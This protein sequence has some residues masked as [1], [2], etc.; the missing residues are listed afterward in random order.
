MILSI[1]YKS[2]QVGNIHLSPFQPDKYGKP[3][4]KLAYKDSSIEFHDVCVLTPPM[5]V[6]DYNPETSRLRLDLTDQTVFQNK[7]HV[8]QEFLMSTFYIHQN[9]FLS[10][11]ANIHDFHSIF[12]LLLRDNILS[13]YIFP[14]FTMK[15]DDNTYYKVSDL[16][17]GDVIRCVIRFSG[18]S[19]IQTRNGLSLRIQHTIPSM[20]KISEK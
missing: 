2:L 12:N 4:A 7:L 6:L 17:N 9:T 3:I 20:W 13:L 5:R 11:Q 16:K 10:L 14:N 8:F 15:K 18:I 1:P 19:Q